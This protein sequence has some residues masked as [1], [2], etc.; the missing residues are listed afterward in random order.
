MHHP[1]VI[2]RRQKGFSE[3]MWQSSFS[4]DFKGPYHIQEKETKE[5]KAACKKDIKLRNFARFLSDKRD[6]EE[7]WDLAQKQKI[8]L[9][10]EQ[11]RV[12]DFRARLGRANAVKALKVLQ[13]KERP[14]FHHTEATSLIV[15]KRGRG[16][17]NWYRY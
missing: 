9:K 12:N 4:Y 14:T 7:E 8:R 3:F 15:L 10:E 16:G 2:V 1:H 6:W 5:E 11:I 13:A 17:I